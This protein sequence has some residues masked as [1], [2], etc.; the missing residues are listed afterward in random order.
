MIMIS[1]SKSGALIPV[2]WDTTEEKAKLD[3]RLEYS[4]PAPPKPKLD[5][6]VYKV[7][8]PSSKSGILIRPRKDTSKKK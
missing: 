8:L 6:P 4:K 1:G 7:A 2:G 3:K 5:S